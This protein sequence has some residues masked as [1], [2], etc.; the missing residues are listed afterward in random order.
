MNT[1]LF[2]V[3]RNEP[4]YVKLSDG[5]ILIIRV[6]ITDIREIRR[7]PTGLIF[8]VGHS[9]SVAAFSPES[10]KEIVKDKPKPVGLDYLKKLDVWEFIDIVECKNSIDECLYYG[11]DGLTYR[12]SIEIEPTIASRT[13]EFRDEFMN[14][15]YFV[16]W[17]PK[18]ITKIEKR[19]ER[20]MG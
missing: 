8:N 20:K 15:V 9:V 14:P 4:G 17:S 12:I 13:L 11:S 5:T 19:M 2:E 18:I 3:I 7:E 16:R 10:L 6:V 1:P